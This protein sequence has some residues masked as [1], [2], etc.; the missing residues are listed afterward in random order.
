MK[1][2]KLCCVIPVGPNQVN[3]L[4]L[5]SS[6]EN[7]NSYE[8]EFILV[9]DGASDSITKELQE[10]C[11]NYSNARLVHSDAR[12]PG[13]ARNLGIIEADSDWLVFFDADKKN[14]KNFF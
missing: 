11:S 3:N 13:G 6:I 14:Y 8:T 2:F 9:L 1:H 5:I 4:N 10:F 12:N 7:G